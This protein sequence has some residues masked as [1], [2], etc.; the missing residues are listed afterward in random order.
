MQVDIRQNSKDLAGKLQGVQEQIANFV[1]RNDQIHNEQDLEKIEVEAQTLVKQLGDLIIA[2][3]V[4][5]NLDESSALQ[6]STK[7]LVH[8]VK[9]KDW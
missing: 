3:K 2:Q 8:H 4:Q 6:D 5:Q 7:E 9:K 1:A